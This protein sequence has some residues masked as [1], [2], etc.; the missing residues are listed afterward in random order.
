VPGLPLVNGLVRVP[1]GPIAPQARLLRELVLPFLR[2]FALVRGRSPH[3]IY[4]Y[5]KDLKS[6][7]GFCDQAE[8]AEPTAVTFRH[9]EFYLGWLQAERGLVPRSANRHLHTLR[10]FWT[11]L[12][13]EGIVTNNPP[14]R[15]F[16]IRERHPLPNHLTIPEQVKILAVLA[17][18]RSLL[19]RRD[20]ALVA[21]LLL[22]GLRCS[23]LAA[24][25]VAHLDLTP[26]TC[27]LRVING[28][29][30]KDREVPIVPQLEKILRA[31]LDK[32]RPALVGRP[33]GCLTRDTPGSQWSLR[34]GIGRRKL[35]LNLET[36]S[37]EEAERLRAELIP[38]PAAPPFV[39]VN[40][41]HTGSRLAHRAGL[42]LSTKTVFQTVRRAVSPIV[43]QPVYPHMLRHSLGT[44]L[45]E[46]GADLVLIKDTLGHAS[47]NTTTIYTHL[48]TNRQRQEL[49]RLL[50]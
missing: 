10:S 47:I 35:Y 22:T 20:Y 4:N 50:E 24:L 32:V 38:P 34:Q 1:A 11:Y 40:A 28:K 3:T 12:E 2:W 16:S 8:L 27:H 45:Y 13:R 30:G 26:D 44:R 17:A 21:T 6:F 29:G 36:H 48:T 19:A 9:I 31:Y 37:R 5:G 15:C 33:I 7:L 39:F 41:H 18:G 14:A 42:A 46:K 23:E 43:G 49:A 25:Q